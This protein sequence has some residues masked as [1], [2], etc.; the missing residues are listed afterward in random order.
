MGFYI[1]ISPPLFN[2]DGYT[3][4]LQGL[5]PLQNINQTHLIWVP[6][7]WMLW[8][9]SYLFHMTSTRFFQLVSMLI[10][11][12][13][14][15][16]SFRLWRS[17]SQS[18]GV[19]AVLTLFVACSPPVWYLGSQ[20]EPYPLLF[21]CVVNSL[22]CE[23]EGGQRP[24]EASTAF[25]LILATLLH[26]AAVLLCIGYALTK[27]SL[28]WLIMVGFFIGASYFLVAYLKG[29]HSLPDFW[30]WLIDYLHTQHHLQ[31]HWYEDLAKSIVGITN[32]LLPFESNEDRLYAHFNDRQIRGG[33]LALCGIF[34]VV[35]AS[36]VA[37]SSFRR[38]I[39][40]L[41]WREE[42]ILGASAALLIAWSVFAIFW[43]P[44]NYYWAVVFFP[45]LTLTARALRSKTSYRAPLLG[46]LF[47]LSGW[48]L[49]ADI[50]SDRLNAQRFPDPQLAII[51]QHVKKTDLLLFLKQSWH[52]GVD[53]DL[54]GRCLTLEGYRVEYVLD[55][56]A[57]RHPSVW[58]P[59]LGARFARASRNNETIFV[60]QWIL[61][62]D[63]YGNL[64]NA[65]FLSSYVM[66]KYQ[67]V[68][69]PE[70]FSE[71]QAFFQAHPTQASDLKLRHD[72]L[73]TVIPG[74]GK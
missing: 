45:A 5:A 50:Q 22:S 72:V 46:I 59:R 71:V 15:F 36:L 24:G 60:S 58:R 6:F 68:S 8:Q 51:R 11:A 64:A 1:F 40:S 39:R 26:Q 49:Y 4:R 47:L 73:V 18:A 21:L 32:T 62:P 65:Y 56:Y 57:I 25:W 55:H 43:E 14:Y 53:Y 27:K 38:W 29:I 74:S 13:V 10:L 69:G 19:A 54:L 63:L 35:S 67:A 37:R 48:N 34:T 66:E 16:Q 3:Y 7:Q 17:L 52:N 33:L 9:V 42:P 20:N 2:Y 70:L 23:G 44:T 61:R 31:G 28:V 41:P 12:A 30:N